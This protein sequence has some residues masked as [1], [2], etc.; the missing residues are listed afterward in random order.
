MM[1]MSWFTRADQKSLSR[2]PHTGCSLSPPRS[3]FACRSNTVVLTAVCSLAGS[4]VG[5][6]VK[7]LAMRNC[8]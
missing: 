7:V 6:S 8:T 1:R 5:L 3:G 2:A 4:F